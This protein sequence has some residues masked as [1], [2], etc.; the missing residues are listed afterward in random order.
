MKS[1]LSSEKRRMLNLLDARWAVGE[2]VK[3]RTTLNLKVA[4]LLA[5]GALAVAMSVPAGAFAYA[6]DSGN[7]TVVEIKDGAVSSVSFDGDDVLDDDPAVDALSDSAA[8]DWT[9]PAERPY[10]SDTVSVEPPQDGVHPEGWVEPEGA[11]YD[12][13]WG[14][15][16]KFEFMYEE[17]DHISNS[18]GKLHLVYTIGADAEGDQIVAFAGTDV[19]TDYIKTEIE[20]FLKSTGMVFDET[21]AWT[22]DRYAAFGGRY[23]P[24]TEEVENGG[25]AN[26]IPGDRYIFD[27]IIKSESGHTYAYKDGS[28]RLSTET[29]IPKD[30]GCLIAF[31]GQNISGTNYAK[32]EVSLRYNMN[33]SDTKCANTLVDR[34]LEAFPPSSAAKTRDKATISNVKKAVASYLADKYGSADSYELF[35]LDFFNEKY[36]TSYVTLQELLGNNREAYDDLVSTGSVTLGKFTVPHPYLYNT[37]YE[38]ILGFVFGDPDDVEAFVYENGASWDTEGNDVAV[39]D[40]MDSTLSSEGVWADTNAYFKQLLSSGLTADEASWVAFNLAF[41]LDGYKMGNDYMQTS[42]SWASNIVLDQVD[43]DLTVIKYDNEGNIIGDDEDESNAS[44]YLW[45]IDDLGTEDTSDDVAMYYTKISGD[46]D[47]DSLYGFVKYDPESGLS[48]TIDA[49]N[50]KVEISNSLLE[51][52]VYYL[53]E[54]VAPEGFERDTN[55]YVICDEDQLEQLLNDEGEVVVSN[56]ASGENDVAAVWV[57]AGIDSDD[58]LTINFVN[59]STPVPPTPP[60]PPT[61]GPEPDPTPDPDSDSESL[62]GKASYEKSALPQTGDANV[63]FGEGAGIAVIASGALFLASRRLRGKSMPKHA[64]F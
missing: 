1:C 14:S 8:I 55:I 27:I 46:T 37:L 33:L 10:T 16:K 15:T 35:A 44:F 3:N 22:G 42:W 39:A 24:K 59:E 56:A 50:G 2:A 62:T 40:Y 54:A 25:F 28:F 64:R 47:E 53:Q 58:P 17:P 20:N 11:D 61:P 52:I 26:L 21:I 49:T 19:I 32:S 13:H 31:D 34:A 45:Y 12:P 60:T 6:D 9:D 43:G 30:E 63:P 23:N 38:S 7:G 29:V 4:S 51:T 48:W 18:V 57:G 36:E 41:N 5:A